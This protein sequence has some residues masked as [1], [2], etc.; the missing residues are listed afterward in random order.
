MNIY[1]LIADLRRKHPT[2]DASRTLDMVVTELGRSRDNLRQAAAAVEAKP[3]P[4]EGKEVLEELLETARRYGIDDLDYGPAPEYAGVPEEIDEGT[5]G[6]AILLGV[7]SLLAIGLA[8][9]AVVNGLNSI[10]HFF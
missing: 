7:S 3:L 4:P 6:I 10:F 8:A 5:R 9:A 2:P 1:L